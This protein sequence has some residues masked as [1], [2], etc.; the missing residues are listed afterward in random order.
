MDRREE[1]IVC[2]PTCGLSQRLGPVPPRHAALCARCGSTLDTARAP[3][4]IPTVACSL[5]A[6]IFYVPANIFPVLTMQRY[7]LYSEA[8][9]W[10]GVVELARM[11]YWFIAAVVFMA[12][13]AVP[14]FKLLALFFL[15]ATATLRTR[16]WRR[17][18]TLLYRAIDIVG[19]WAMLDVFLLA[20]L[21]ALV[22]LGSL[23]T[24]LP[25]RGMLA[26]ACVVVLTLLASSFFDPRLIWQGYGE[27]EKHYRRRTAGAEA[28]A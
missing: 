12:S 15:S 3:S 1:P 4:V 10:Q 18:R 7:G 28:N 13:I 16:R 27:A 26:F 11:G 8:T 23:A 22:R 6:L 2:C 20:I 24:V 25:G 14:L 19:P 9:V 5:A 17:E 21:V